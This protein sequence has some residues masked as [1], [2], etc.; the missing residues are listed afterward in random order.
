MSNSLFLCRVISSNNKHVGTIFGCVCCDF[1]SVLLLAFLWAFGESAVTDFCVMSCVGGCDAMALWDAVL[2]RVPGRV[3]S[4]SCMFVG[5]SFE[6]CFMAFFTCFADWSCA[7]AHLGPTYFTDT[8]HFS[9]GVS[10]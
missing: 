10:D 8:L 4:G 7:Q 2:C 3:S 9:D 5:I 6:G 1:C